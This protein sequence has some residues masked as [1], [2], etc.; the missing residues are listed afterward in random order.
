MQRHVLYF[1]QHF[2]ICAGGRSNSSEKK[3]NLP[4]EFWQI[5]IARN[6]HQRNLLLPV[7]PP[8]FFITLDVWSIT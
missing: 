7:W 6:A 2:T 3:K 5:K 1:L 4:H 8:L